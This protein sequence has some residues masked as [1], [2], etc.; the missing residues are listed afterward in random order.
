M[1]NDPHRPFH[2]IHTIDVADGNKGAAIV[3]FPVAK[4]DRRDRHPVMR[5]RKVEL[6]SKRRPATPHSD[7]GFLDGRVLVEYWDIVDLIRAGVNMTADVGQNHALEIFV[8][9]I[10]GAERALDPVRGE[11]VPEDIRIVKAGGGVLIER[12]VRVWRPFL[13]IRKRQ[14]TFINFH[15]RP[16]RSGCNREQGETTEHMVLHRRGSISGV[17]LPMKREL[18]VCICLR[19]LLPEWRMAYQFRIIC[20]QRRKLVL[21]DEWIPRFDWPC[22][23]QRRVNFEMHRD[24]LLRTY[25]DCVVL[26]QG[27]SSTLAAHKVSDNR[28]SVRQI[29]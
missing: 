4:I 13:I 2:S 20:V 9:Q 1:K 7:R 6:Q 3:L 27:E 28:A 17:A 19:S 22:F 14:R 15:L 18:A 21:W 26:R 29:Q 16:E 8:L 24:N 10:N 25:R 12:S 23:G 11:I 5:D